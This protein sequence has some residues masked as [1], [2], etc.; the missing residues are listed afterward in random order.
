MKLGRNRLIAIALAL[1][2]LGGLGWAAFAP[3]AASHEELFEIPKGTAARRLASELFASSAIAGAR[4]S[5]AA[6][7]PP[8]STS[9]SVVCAR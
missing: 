5:M 8:R 7:V 3:V 4:R 6:V 1:P 9:A 2:L